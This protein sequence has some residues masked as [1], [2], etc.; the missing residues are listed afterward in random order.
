M[1]NDLIN[2]VRFLFT[3]KKYRRIFFIESKFIENHVID[4]VL[5]EN[6]L[7][8]TILLTFYQ[9]V[10]SRVHKNSI[11]NFFFKKP[12]FLNFIFYFIK[13]PLLYSSTPDLNNSLFVKSIFKQT[14]YVYIQHSP[15]G[16]L[17]IYNDN[18]FDSFD[19]I[20]VVNKFQIEDIKI[21]NKKK[22]LKIRHFKSQ[23]LFF[24]KKKITDNKNIKPR[25]LIAPSHSTDFY[26]KNYLSTLIEYID[27][28]DFDLYF[29]PH[30]MSLI[31]K[32]FSFE[33]IQKKI[34]IDNGILNL[35][36]YDL[37]ITDWSGIFIEFS[38]LKRQKSVLLETSKKQLS[39]IFNSNLDDK[40]SDFIFR[41]KLGIKLFNKDLHNINSILKDVMKNKDEYRL[42]IN[43]FFKNNFF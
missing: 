17:M 7:K 36:S 4:Y 10:D 23:Y 30:A 31:K 14:K 33:N 34:K 39:N 25:L 3:Q 19:F 5:K 27:K 43:N 16:L 2:C 9:D 41:D 26:R 29:R 8:N 35:N 38:F 18:A 11:K 20:Q 1:V 24:K 37:L 22:D 13:I 42:D 40:Y 32:E 21:I 28:N 6:R 15:L 12:F